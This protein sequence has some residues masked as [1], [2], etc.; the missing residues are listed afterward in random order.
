MDYYAGID[1]GGTKI[2]SVIIDTAGRRLSRAKVK[3]GHDH[4]FD[5]V[6]KRIRECYDKALE[7]AEL[8]DSDIKALGAAVPSAVNLESGTIIHA[9]NLGWKN[10]KAPEIFYKMFG[11]PVFLDNDVNLGT[12]G[13]IGRAS[14]RERV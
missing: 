9:P 2:Y 3:T 7:K 6:M 8:E 10:I 11:K 13:E 1:V 4:D 12:F 14:C 5:S